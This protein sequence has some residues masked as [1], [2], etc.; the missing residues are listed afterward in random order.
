[1]ADVLYSFYYWHRF[2]LV[3]RLTWTTT[4]VKLI[5]DFNILLFYGSNF[6]FDAL[7]LL[8]YHN[9]MLGSMIPLF[10]MN[11]SHYISR[12][13][14]LGKIQFFWLWTNCQSRLCIITEMKSLSKSFYFIVI[15]TWG[16]YILHATC[17]FILINAKEYHI[18]AA[19][20]YLGCHLSITCD[21]I[22]SVKH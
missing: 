10:F 7:A 22:L 5:L 18:D 6:M 3:L 8:L 13:A 14:H 12:T 2:S 11:C 15:I 17:K 19:L 21:M 16:I 1:M 20:T 4:Q 9:S